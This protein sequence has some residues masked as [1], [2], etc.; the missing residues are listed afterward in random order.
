M[1][2][3]M[4]KTKPLITPMDILVGK[5]TYQFVH[6]EDVY[7]KCKKD[8]KYFGRLTKAVAKTKRG[9]LGVQAH[10][11]RVMIAL[12][13]A[14][15]KNGYVLPQKCLGYFAEN[16]MIEQWV[17]RLEEAMDRKY[18]FR[19]AQDHVWPRKPGKPKGIEPP[20][21]QCPWPDCPDSTT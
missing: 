21:G 15:L 19:K 3:A 5:K 4:A 2:A 10:K 20:R 9:G 14:I 18:S 16:L 11:K 17:E 8:R 12:A 7:E 1:E 6:L 13:G